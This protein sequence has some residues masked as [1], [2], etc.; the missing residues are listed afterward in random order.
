MREKRKNDKKTAFT[1]ISFAVI[2]VLFL[3]SVRFAS[4]GNTERQR[5]SLE[6]ALQRDVTYCYATTGRYPKTL[7]YIERAYGLTYDKDLFEVEYIVKGSRI[8]PD[9]I[10]T[11]KGEGNE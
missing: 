4:Q 10:I 3:I 9:I 2:M 11:E 5:E 8:P 7:G 6:K 1:L